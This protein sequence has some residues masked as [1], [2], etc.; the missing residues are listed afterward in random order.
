MHQGQRRKFLV[1]AS[2]LLA[3]RFAHAQ[4]P[5]KVTVGF[6]SVNARAAMSDR[7]EAFQQGL[8]EL[9]YAE[10]ENI[11]VEYRYA[12][13]NPDRLPGLAAELVRMN[14]RVIVT[15]G[16]TATRFAKEATSTIPIVMAQDP[17]PVGTGFVASLARPGG[18]ITGLSNL[19]AELSAKRLE[20]LKEAVPGLARVA[21]CARGAG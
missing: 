20:L 6:L 11:F 10:G 4:Q 8:R 13:A 3:A 2:A 21:G 5:R 9:G 14:V 7:T 17:D 15:E 18:N 12:N 16:T 19:R 1:V